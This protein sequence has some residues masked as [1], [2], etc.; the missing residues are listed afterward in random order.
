MKKQEKNILIPSVITVLIIAMAIGGYYIWQSYKTKEIIIDENTEGS[1]PEGEDLEYMKTVDSKCPVRA[2][3]SETYNNPNFTVS[4]VYCA[5]ARDEGDL[6]EDVTVEIYTTD[7]EAGK[8]QFRD[9][10]ADNGLEES[11]KLRVEYME[12]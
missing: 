6:G 1:A 12:K 2:I 11:E 9:W 4:D 5:F 10:L 8:Q 3:K 7:F